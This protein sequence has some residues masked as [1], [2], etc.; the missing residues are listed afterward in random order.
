[1]VEGAYYVWTPAQLV[2]VLGEE[3]GRIAAAHF[4]VTEEGTFEEGASVLRLP[5]EDGAVQDAG[6]IASIRERLYE[7][8]GERQFEIKLKGR[9]GETDKRRRPL[10]S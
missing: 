8:S 1:M 2:E 4:G 9:R 5:Q 6:R 7:H 3:D 10:L